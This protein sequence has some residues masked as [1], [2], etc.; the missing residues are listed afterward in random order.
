MLISRDLYD[1]PFRDEEEPSDEARACA[2]E[3]E[4]QRIAE[5]AKGGEA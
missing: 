3:R 2:D 1:D 4:E 5:Y